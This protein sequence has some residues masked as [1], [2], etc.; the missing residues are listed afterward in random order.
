M[1]RNEKRN[2]KNVAASAE[3][4]G[5]AS[6][7]KAAAQVLDLKEKV[8]ALVTVFK[9]QA[10]RTSQAAKEL[11]GCFAGVL[12]T[13]RWGAYNIYPASK[14]HRPLLPSPHP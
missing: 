13:G 12:H 4:S 11:L 2:E 10:R 14:T 1:P 7:E 9:V 6:C 8:A 5:C 3:I